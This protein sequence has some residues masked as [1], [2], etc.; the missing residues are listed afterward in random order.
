[1]NRG[2]I[3]LWRKVEDCSSFSRGAGHV[4]MMTLCLIRANRSPKMFMGTLIDRGSFA[5]GIESLGKEIRLSRQQSRDVFA[6]LITDEF[7]TIKGTKLFSVI[8]ICNWAIYQS[9]EDEKE[10]SKEPRENQGGTKEEPQSENKRIRELI[11]SPVGEVAEKFDAMKIIEWW[12][13]IAKRNGVSTIK[14]MTDTRIKKWKVRTAKDFN[15]DAIEVA[16][17]EAGTFLK[18]GTWFGFDWIIENETNAMKLIE[19]NYRDKKPLPLETVRPTKV[20]L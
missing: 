7:V 10:P 6:D 5:C 15:L 13:T 14:E 16:I 17:N 20:V 1:V 9:D 18:T 4:A 2:Y 19:G 11:L 8:S 3:K 12:N